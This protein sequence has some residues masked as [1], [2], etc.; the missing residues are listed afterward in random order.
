MWVVFVCFLF[1]SF[2]LAIL[3]VLPSRKTSIKTPF[4]RDSTKM[5]FSPLYCIKIYTQ[6]LKSLSH[7]T[8]KY[9][10]VYSILKLNIWM[11]ELNP[12]QV[13]HIIL[14]T[15]PYRKDRNLLPWESPS[16]LLFWSTLLCV[17]LLLLFQSQQC[18]T[19]YNQTLIYVFRFIFSI[20]STL[21]WIWSV[22][23]N[24]I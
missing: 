18:T 11:V 1:C 14:K 22:N 4:S 16:A 3:R 6:T 15:F 12:L 20:S 10:E 23:I 9:L 21:F 2:R 8:Q 5:I 13:Y 24:S 7:E 17:L 19:V